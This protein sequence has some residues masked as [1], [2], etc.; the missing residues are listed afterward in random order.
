MLAVETKKGGQLQY[1][2]S[3]VLGRHGKTRDK[4]GK[5][6]ECRNRKP[7]VVVANKDKMWRQ[8]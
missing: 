1:K 4:M 6:Q 7:V 3:E 5:E 2:R 8:E